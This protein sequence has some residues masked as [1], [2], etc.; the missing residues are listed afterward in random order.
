MPP[1][2]LAGLI[3]NG[4]SG[5][6]QNFVPALGLN[7]RTQHREP[8]LSMGAVK[9]VDG[10]DLTRILF[11]PQQLARGILGLVVLTLKR[12]SCREEMDVVAMMGGAVFAGFGAI[13]GGEHDEEG[14]R[15]GVDV[16]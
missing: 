10:C 15:V 11:E 8:A 13:V 5:A 1:S 6:V 16:V 3:G 14:A 2:L 9:S 4:Q 12:V 7:Q